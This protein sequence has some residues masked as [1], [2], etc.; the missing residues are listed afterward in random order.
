MA[1]PTANVAQ[2]YQ[3]TPRT[4]W[5]DYP[6]KAATHLY[7]GEAVTKD[8]TTGN[9]HDLT[10]NEDF[11]GFVE[12]EAN[13]VAGGSAFSG[14]TIGDGTEGNITANIRTEGQILLTVAIATLVG[15]AA[16]KD[17]KVYGTDGQTFTDAS[18]GNAVLIGT[19]VDFVVK[20][21]ATSAQYIVGFQSTQKR[22]Q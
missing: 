11:L 15:G 22:N 12:H 19:I 3:E 18:A 16:D 17:S 13:N 4:D 20:L 9:A 6:V 7:Q 1:A 2:V 5:Y 21:S 14:A 10:T 8:A